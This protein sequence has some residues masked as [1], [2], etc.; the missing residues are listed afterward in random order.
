MTAIYPQA[1]ELKCNYF[2]TLELISQLITNIGLGF[3]KQDFYLEI[4]AGTYTET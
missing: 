4:Y 3:E 2:G 1:G